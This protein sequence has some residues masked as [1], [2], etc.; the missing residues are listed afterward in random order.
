MSETTRKQKLRNNLFIVIEG[1][2]GSGKTT[3]SKLL[4]QRF[5]ENNLPCHRTFEQTKGPIGELIRSILVGDIKNIENETIALLFAADRYQHLKSEILP[6]LEHS[7][8]ICDRYYYSSMAY[9]GIDT[10]VMTRIIDYNQVVIAEHKP[11]IMFFIDVESN[12]CLRRIEAR[13]DEVSIYDSLPALAMRY[14][15]YKAATKRM[16]NTD[17]IV[18]VGN[19]TASAE[20]IVDE[21]WEHL[22]KLFCIT[23]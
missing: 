8:V 14:V 19:N 10:N 16:K 23:P 11:D 21:M 18:T 12:E 15:S 2:D 20:N 7:H 17:N 22:R 5:A 3:V 9:Q 6:T 4:T 1:L 13:G